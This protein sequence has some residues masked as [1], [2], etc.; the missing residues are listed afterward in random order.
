MA[1][2]DRHPRIDACLHGLAWAALIVAALLW[3]DPAGIAAR[4][5]A[6]SWLAVTA[7]WL[8]L[9]CILAALRILVQMTAA[10][11]RVQG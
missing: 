7:A 10:I 1:R 9:S 3:L 11:D 2:I 8:S 4:L 5:E 6:A